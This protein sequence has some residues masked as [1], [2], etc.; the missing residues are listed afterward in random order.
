[1]G[2]FLLSGQGRRIGFGRLDES[3]Q[4]FRRHAHAADYAHNIQVLQFGDLLV[5]FIVAGAQD[6]DLLIVFAALGPQPVDF[7]AHR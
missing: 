7:A 1:M 5:D 2:I 6:S 3:G 4:L